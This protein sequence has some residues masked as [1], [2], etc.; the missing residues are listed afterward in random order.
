ML[1]V[2]GLPPTP[3]DKVYEVWWIGE[4]QGPLKAGLFEPLGQ[5]AP[6]SCRSICRRL[7]EVVLASAIA[8]R[9]ESSGVEKPTGAMYMKGDFP[10]PLA[11]VARA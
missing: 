11:K 4:K 7:D 10:A 1:Q 9:A 2:S 6:Q 5:Q 3:D 8:L